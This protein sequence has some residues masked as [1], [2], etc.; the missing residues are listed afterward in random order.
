MGDPQ[1]SSECIN[2]ALWEQE[3][4]VSSSDGFIPL[5]YGSAVDTSNYFSVF[6]LRYIPIN[7]NFPEIPK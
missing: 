2:K 5:S 4:S 6:P 3:N 7:S 1:S